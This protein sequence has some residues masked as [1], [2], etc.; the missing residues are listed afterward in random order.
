MDVFVVVRSSIIIFKG[1]EDVD[2]IG[3]AIIQLPAAKDP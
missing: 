2:V 3:L 1:P